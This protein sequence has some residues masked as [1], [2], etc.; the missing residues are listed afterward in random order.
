MKPLDFA[1]DVANIILTKKG[2][3]I[4]ILNLKNLSSVSD[5]FL[6]CSADSDVQVKAIADE[7]DKKLSKQ[8][9]KC[10]HK[11]GF[12]SLNWVLLDYFDVIVHIFKEE[13]RIYYNL[14]KLWGDAPVIDIADEEQK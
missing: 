11:E 14:E 7:I 4:K 13:S 5:Y 10:Y 6:I 2:Y 1:K 8:G 3:D 9:I 12:E